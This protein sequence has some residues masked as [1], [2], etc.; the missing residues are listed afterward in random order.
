MPVVGSTTP[1]SGLEVR[2]VWLWPQC[3]QYCDVSGR[4]ELQYQ[5]VVT[6]RHSRP[7]AL[8]YAPRRRQSGPVADQG[9]LFPVPEGTE[10]RAP[11]ATRM[12]PRTF[13]QLVGQ[14][15]VVEVLR[16]LTR[17]GNLPSI[18][19]WGPPGSG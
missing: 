4:S 2:S 11:L 3:G 19:L 18:I 13:D 5:Q 16:S 14:R 6:G 10:P 12:R 17:A 15:R 1:K 7:E 9:E 8:E